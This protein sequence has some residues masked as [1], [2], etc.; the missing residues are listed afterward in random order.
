MGSLSMLK[1]FKTMVDAST[2]K[3]TKSRS[4]LK[5]VFDVLERQINRAVEENDPVHLVSA[6]V[7]EAI[8]TAR[9]D[10]RGRHEKYAAALD[11]LAERWGY[12]LDTVGP[13]RAMFEIEHF[14]LAKINEDLMRRRTV[15]ELVI[16][17]LNA[18]GTN[19][20]NQVTYFV[21]NFDTGVMEDELRDLVR[22][23][24][25]G[26]ERRMRWMERLVAKVTVPDR[27]TGNNRQPEAEVFASFALGAAKLL[28]FEIGQDLIR[29]I[30]GS[31]R[32][33]SII[34][35]Y[36]WEGFATDFDNSNSVAAGSGQ[37]NVANAVLT[38]QLHLGGIR[39]LPKT[40]HAVKTM[41]QAYTRALK[42]PE[43]TGRDIS[44]KILGHW[45]STHAIHGGVPSVGRNPKPVLFVS[46]AFVTFFHELCHVVRLIVGGAWPQDVVLPEELQT[47]YQSAEELFNIQ[48]AEPHFSEYNL[49]TEMGYPR[50][51][52]HGGVVIIAPTTDRVAPW[53]GYDELYMGRR[54]RIDNM[55]TL[56]EHLTLELGARTLFRSG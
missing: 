7:A 24:T 50:R 14:Q 34:L 35:R 6:A 26:D 30:V 43:G 12:D 41:Q 37:L 18:M 36:T 11:W 51:L 21:Q 15:D 32:G 55:N 53:N 20:R 9:R 2:K 13:L 47:S 29:D 10:R 39:G 19:L 28:A 54:P 5:P 49:L 40:V 48:A 42:R 22:S 52:T 23:M 1:T 56:N 33:R 45:S 27:G 25:D 44:L 38:P 8:T 3:F 46:P 31:I 4:S 16:R 17:Q